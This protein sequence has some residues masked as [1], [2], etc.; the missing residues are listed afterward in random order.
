MRA[1]RLA[2][3]AVLIAT[4]LLWA[5]NW[6]VAR[7]VRHEIS[8]AIATMLR[9]LIVIWILLPFVFSTM[10]AEL[11]KLDAAKW[12]TLLALGFFGGGLHLAM[13]WLGLHYTTATSATLYLSVS[14]IFILLL[15]GPVLGEKIRRRQW[16]GVFV[17]LC[18]VVLIGT[19]GNLNEVGFNPGDALALASMLM[20]GAYTV[21]L[22]L[23]RDT[24][25]TPHFLAVICALGFAFVSPW[26][27][28]E[29][30]HDQTPNLSAAG[31]LAVAYSAIGSM[32]LAYAGWN[33]AVKRLGAARAGAAMHLTPAFAVILAAIFLGEYPVWYHF[34]GL[35]LILAGVTISSASSSR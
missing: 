4:L 23:R 18:G 22:R 24:L 27:I 7:A 17:S 13:Q 10:R 11:A 35:A 15:A 21:W 26:G 30:L 16:A 34:A 29:F 9:Q 19:Q 2:A 3:P 33:Y 28:W 12:R 5:G 20:W 8:P 6:I 31:M 25:D 14:P 1:M 32:L